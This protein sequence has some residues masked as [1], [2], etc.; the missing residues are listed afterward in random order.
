LSIAGQKGTG[1]T[2]MAFEIAEH[3]LKQG[4]KL[5]TNIDNVWSDPDMDYQLKNN[6]DYIKDSVL[7]LDEGGR[8]LREWKY[9]EDMFE[10]A[11]KFNNIILIPST[12]VAHEN[13]AE[14][15]ARPNVILQRIL[16]TKFNWWSYTVKTGDV[17]I[18]GSFYFNPTVIGVYD[19]LDI[20]RNPLFI[21]EAFGRLISAEAVR[22]GR[23][24][25]SVSKMGGDSDFSEQ[26]EI[27]R[28]SAKNTEN[29]LSILKR[30]RKR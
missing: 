12:R 13:L 19:T 7:I 3:Y 4:Y 28:A 30:S 25:D 26:S 9:F 11:R 5:I 17:D 16:P 10:Y 18:N 21:I 2:A 27:I 1:K 8:Y 15:I 22:R 20:S 6:V 23:P 24:A 29:L 14:F